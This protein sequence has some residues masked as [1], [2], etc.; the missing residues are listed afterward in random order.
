MFRSLRPSRS[1]AVPSCPNREPEQLPGPRARIAQERALWGLYTQEVDMSKCYVGIDVSRDALDVYVRPTGKAWQVTNTC[2][3]HASLAQRLRRLDPKL[4][5]LEATGGLERAAARALAGAGLA[6]AV[7]N[8]RQTRDFARSTG[9]V[10]KTDALDA[11]DLA[12]YAEVVQPEPRTLADEETQALAELVRRR[13]QVVKMA[14]GEKNRLQRC[15]G[16]LRAGI[17]DHLSWLEEEE[18]RLDREIQARVRSEPRWRARVKLLK[19]VPGVGPVLSSTLVAC[20]PELGRV[21]K[22][23]IAALVGVAPFN[24]DSGKK[25]GKRRV[26]GGRGH[27]RAVL[28]MATVAAVRCNP[29]LKEFYQRLV[30]AGKEKKVALTASMRRLIVI[31]NAIAQTGTPW[32][33][34]HAAS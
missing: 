15:S 25:R 16:E 10:A 30:D 7:V 28:Y 32:D 14:A 3:G 21:G 20:M 27:V 19:T 29:V 31:L 17:Q 8:P 11:S 4:V 18:E 24:R 5:V 26:S 33:E 1:E 6:V 2:R 22:K 23:E 9:R 34:A 13:L 12:R